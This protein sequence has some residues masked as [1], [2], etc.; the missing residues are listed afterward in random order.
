MFFAMP[1]LAFALFMAPGAEADCRLPDPVRQQMRQVSSLPDGLA[2]YNRGLDYYDYHCY[3]E[4]SAE[5][6]SA[7]TVLSALP[8]PST[9]EKEL[10]G[11]S[12]SARALMEAHLRLSSDRVTAL[13]DMLAVAQ[14]TFP[15]VVKVDATMDL[16]RLLAPDAPQWAQLERVLLTLADQGYWQA[17]KVVA[18]R[19]LARGEDASAYLQQQ[20]ANARRVEFGHAI[21]I[22]LADVWRASGRTLEAWLLIRSIERPVGEQVLDPELRLEFLRVAAAVAD[23]RGRTGDTEAASAAAIYEMARRDVEA[24]R[25]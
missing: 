11:L 13:D 22:I 4:A 23:G 9:K 17:T 12:R 7:V 14:H 10:L 16:T 1:V 24:G 15:S 2:H 20:L 5:L 19:K 21:R 6:R 3:S 8:Q 18:H 25:R